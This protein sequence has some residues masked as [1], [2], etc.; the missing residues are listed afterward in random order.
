LRFFEA[1]D[2]LDADALSRLM[3]EDC[4]SVIPGPGGVTT[5]NR[6]DYLA[7]IRVLKAAQKSPAPARGWRDFDIRG[8][9]DTAVMTAY[10]GPAN[11]EG[12]LIE[13]AFVST[14]WI[15]QGDRWQVTYSQRAPAGPSGEVERWNDVFRREAGFNPEPNTLLTQAVQ[16]VKP[17]K[18]LD[19]GMG[20]GRNSV[21]LAQLGWDVTGMDPAEVGLAIG[22]RSAQEANVRITPVLQTAEEFDWG[23]ARWDLIAVIYMNPRGLKE[24]IRT[25]LKPG[26]LLVVEGFHRD[27]TKEGKIAA[28]V[29]YDTDELK[30]MLPDF[31]IVHYEEPVELPDFGPE[32]VRLVRLIAR[33]KH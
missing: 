17:G 32:K 20:Q 19:V 23:Q 9:G 4:V 22:R 16:G 6:S 13:E 25:S 15:H 30:N 28:G 7:R 5:I 8:I 18:A 27:A 26:G 10:T 2:R 11:P 33:K 1:L 29:V 24:Q 21:Y 12:K 14:V 31:D 3:T